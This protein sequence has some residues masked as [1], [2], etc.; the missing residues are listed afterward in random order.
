MAGLKCFKYISNKS[1]SDVYEIYEV[2]MS[3]KPYAITI[4]KS[5][6]EDALDESFFHIMKH[7][8]KSKGDLVHYATRVVGKILLSKNKKEIANDEVLEIASESSAYVDN[9]E[10]QD[11]SP[12]FLL[13]KNELDKER[14]DV[15]ACI[16]MLK[17]YFIKDFKFFNTQDPSQRTLSYTEVFNRFS[18]DTINT[19][20]KYLLANNEGIEELYKTASTC[21]LRKFGD[22]R[23]QKG[24]DPFVKY[25]GE[26]NNIVL[27]EKKKGSHVKVVYKLDFDKMYQKLKDLFYSEG[28][29]CRAV[30][31]GTEVFA[32]L[33]GTIVIGDKELRRV[34][35]RDLV[36]CILTRTKYPLLQIREGKDVLLSCSSEI[37][38]NLF[39]EFYGEEVE[40]EFERI[41]SKEVKPKK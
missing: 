5:R 28:G 21:A 33:T 38:Y 23:F 18:E 19:A 14:K 3:L 25:L 1:I 13:E 7:Y 37:K 22:E 17:E 16:D 24:Y 35:E 2:V 8:D 30:V 27:F 12:Y 40:L 26:I 41:V 29:K 32:T 6:W 20:R 9:K 31:D 36:G 10:G 4:Y 11:N 39:Q 34:L 15:K